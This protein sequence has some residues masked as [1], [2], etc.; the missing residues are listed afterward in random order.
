MRRLSSDGS[1]QETRALS[2][3]A[4]AKGAMVP[5]A[6]VVRAVYP[7]AGDE[8]ASYRAP[9]RD[10]LRRLRERGI[11]IETVPHKGFALKGVPQD[12]IALDEGGRSRP[13]AKRDPLGPRP[14]LG[15]CKKIFRPAWPGNRMCPACTENA[16]E[17]SGAITVDVW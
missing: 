2:V 9:L 16:R 13:S 4:A 3:L 12:A 7:D 6:E 17:M 5:W 1:T 14:C 11:A 15:R 10:V 8:I